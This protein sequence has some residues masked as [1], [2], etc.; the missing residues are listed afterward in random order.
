MD[1]NN[2][3]NIEC[4]EIDNINITF[5]YFT[6][7]KQLGEEFIKYLRGYRQ[8]SQEYMKKLQIFE[9]N[10]GR[11]I[12]RP[13]ENP[14]VSQ[15]VD[16][17]SKI[18]D[19]IF[20]N[21]ELFD[22]SIKEIDERINDFEK[23]LKE[24]IEIVNNLKKSFTEVGKNLLCQNIEINKTKN[25][26]INS[27]SKTEEIIDKYYIDKSKIQEH[28][29]GL[30]KK[31]TEN[32]YNILKEQQKN[33]LQEMNNSIKLSKK[34]QDF[35]KGSIEA[36]KKLKDNFVKECQSCQEKIRKNTCELSEEI[37]NL[38]CT[39]L[40]SYKNIYKQPLSLIDICINKFNLLEEEKEMDSI[41]VSS[42][43][44]DNPLKYMTPT[45][46]KLKSF[47]HLKSSN[48]LNNQDEINNEE[49]DNKAKNKNNNKEENSL[50]RKSIENLEDG[51]DEMRY[52]CDESLVM[53]IKSLFE[54]F[55]LIEKEDFNIKFEEEKNR[56]QKY[57][58]KIITNMNSYPFAKE[59]FYSNNNLNIAQE[60]VIEYKREELTKE[61]LKDLIELLNIHENRIIF[62]QKFSDYR[63]RGK[64]VLCDKDYILLSQLYNIICDK[65]KKDSDY[66]AAEMVIVLS[67]T[68]YIEEGKKRKYLQ[69]SFKGNK[70]FKD[71][72][73]WEEFLC[74]SINK[75]IMKTLQR[76]Q[77]VKE[78]K[79]NSDYKYSNVVF[80]QILTLIDNMFEFDLDSEIVKEVLN[81]KISYYRLNDEFKQTINDIIEVKKAEKLKK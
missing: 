12:S 63:A 23:Y 64:F 10:F 62:L 27:L 66:H 14:K 7:V 17:T 81:P 25:I 30:G 44:N 43:K 48:Y 61:E 74:Y 51:F 13:A 65:I 35:H 18:T 2:L 5:D 68:Y 39:F 32:E 34:Y 4:S 49:N 38:V 79:E 36:S 53:T 22:F 20:Q 45:K 31:L 69:E 77:L 37:K 59:G 15:L 54:N 6:S 29:S 3:K 80:T 52:I 16:L 41:I 8:L 73:F 1:Q 40:L 75:E 72:N 78:D 60:Y 67:Q 9:T 19:L 21:I 47:S 57:V 28:E 33:Q 71:K 46:Y 26:F 42:Y 58:L 55:D 11:K 70:L 50:V 24:K 76:D 56:A